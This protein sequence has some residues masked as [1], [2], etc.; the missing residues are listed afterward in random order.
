M[1]FTDVPE[2]PLPPTPTREP[3]KKPTNTTIET[4][5]DAPS[6]V[7]PREA[8][9]TRKKVALAPSEINTEITQA[10]DK[11]QCF[12][13]QLPIKE[14][15]GKTMCPINFAKSH[16]AAPLINEWAAKGCPV[17]CGK[18]W[19]EQHICAALKRGPHKL[20]KSRK[21]ILALQQETTEKINSGYARVVTW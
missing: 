8:I 13:S 11:E 5:S 1:E 20:A 9:F 18:D 12:P 16:Q 19:D 3:I 21:A 7:P 10:L 17:D 6:E 2:V 15:I 4:P 14:A